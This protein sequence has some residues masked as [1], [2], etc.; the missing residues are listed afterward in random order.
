[1]IVLD[2]PKPPSVNA[3][4]F[5]KA[6][7]GRVRTSLYNDWRTNA[8]W[9]LRMQK[10]QPINGP[11]S[12][13]YALCDE[14]KGDLGN[15]EKAVTDLLVSH[16]MIDGDSRDVVRRITLEWSS[17]ITGCRVTIKPYAQELT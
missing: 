5:N 15:L 1:M 10:Q 7:K 9:I 4:F 13:S 3:L 14:G 17:Q 2:L 6:G 12:V 11:V 16:R 8:G